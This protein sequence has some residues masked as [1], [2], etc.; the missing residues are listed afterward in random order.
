MTW[1]PREFITGPIALVRLLY[2][3][4]TRG[5]VNRSRLMEELPEGVASSTTLKQVKQVISPDVI[6]KIISLSKKRLT[7]VRE[8]GRE[9]VTGKKDFK[10]AHLLYLSASELAWSLLELNQSL[11]E[12]FATE[13]KGVTKEL[14]LSLGN[15]VEMCL[16]RTDYTRAIIAALG[17]DWVLRHTAP[18]EDVPN[19]IIEKNQRRLAQAKHNLRD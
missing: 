13:F 17:V 10:R 18:G 4:A 19:D 9:C 5:I 15:A 14:V 3:L 12:R 11:N 6:L 2:Q 16:R 1:T 7:A 8:E